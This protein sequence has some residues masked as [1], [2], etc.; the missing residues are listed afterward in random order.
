MLQQHRVLGSGVR[1]RAFTARVSRGSLQV[2]VGEKEKRAQPSHTTPAALR[3]RLACP[4][5]QQR[6]SAYAEWLTP[7]V[8][9][10]TP[11]CTMRARGR[12]RRRSWSS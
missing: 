1:P 11:R 10:H 2:R 6:S 8:P 4:L 9:N 12:T 7:L 3:R 5:Q